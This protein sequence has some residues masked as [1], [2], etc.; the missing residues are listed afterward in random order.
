MVVSYR[1]VACHVAGHHRPDV[2]V[3]GGVANR[4]TLISEGMAD[5]LFLPVGNKPPQ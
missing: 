2:D 5:G 3:G 4:R 1:V